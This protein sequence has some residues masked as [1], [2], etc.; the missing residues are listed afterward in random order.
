MGMKRG[1]IALAVALLAGS[2]ASGAESPTEAAQ[3]ESGPVEVADSIEPEPV[4]DTAVTVDAGVGAEEEEVF[5]VGF[6][7]AVR[8]RLEDDGIAGLSY[9]IVDSSGILAA[10]GHGFAD[11]EAGVPVG[12]DTLFHVGSTHKALN[13]ALVAT[14]V[15]DGVLT[16]DTPV[17]ELF[18][19]AG[20]DGDLTVRDTLTMTAGIAAAVE[21]DL[22]NDVEQASA[23]PIIVDA[24]VAAEPIAAPG[25]AFEYSNVSAALAGYAAAAAV[26]PQSENLHADYLDLFTERVLAPLAMEDSTLL[27]SEALATGRYARA[28]DLDGDD[29]VPVESFDTDIDLLAPSGSLKSTAIDMASFLEVLL[30]DG[31]TPTG[32]PF[33]S[34]ASWATLLR[35]ALEGY[36]MGWEVAVGANGIEYFVHEGAFDGYL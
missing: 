23:A 22:E 25:D 34:S 17:A 12:T 32:E 1:F 3:D 7:D 31:R 30:N 15:D 29:V 18:A 9:A 2:C 10:A 14:L 28:Y 11:V 24:V 27:V 36:A 5:F 20:L 4:T 19:G 13:A 35:P 26:D 8:D 6:D 16:W 33:V 21:D